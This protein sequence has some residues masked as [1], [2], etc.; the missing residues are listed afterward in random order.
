MAEEVL[1]VT[2]LKIM[3]G[4][5]R[6]DERSSPK[7]WL[8]AVIRKTALEQ[9]RR[10]WLDGRLF[11]RVF[12]GRSEPVDVANP[13]SA[14]AG[15]ETSRIVIAAMQR[16]SRRQREVLHLVFYQGLTIEESARVLGLSLGAARVH[17]ERGKG[18]L[19]QLMP[20]EVRP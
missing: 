6:Y 3:T 14:A 12:G 11:S 16:L 20:R 8:F 4:K 5:A 17:Y 15:L 2:Y 9:R 13:E 1:Q 7:T 19:R 10:A 18:R